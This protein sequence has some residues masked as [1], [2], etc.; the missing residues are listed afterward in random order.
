VNKLIKTI[1]TGIFVYSLKFS[2]KRMRKQYSGGERQVRDESPR[3]C[4]PNLLIK[5]GGK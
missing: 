5:A 2:E 3:H 4:P 1:R